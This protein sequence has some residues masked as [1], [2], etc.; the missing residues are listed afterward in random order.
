MRTKVLFTALFLLSVSIVSA[1]RAPA[2]TPQQPAQQD[3]GM[4]LAN[5]IASIAQGVQAMNMQMAVFIEKINSGGMTDKRQKM[6]AGLQALTAAEQRVIF[7]QNNQFDLTLKL[8]DAKAKLAQTEVDLRPMR[9]DRSVQ[10]EGT[11]ETE[12]LRESRRQKLRNDQITLT[13]LV[14]DLGDSL[15]QNTIDLKEAQAFARNLR[16]TYIPQME[17]EMNEQ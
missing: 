5:S 16:K 7:F 10:F 9:I 11:T 2:Q 12:E 14:R 1:Q 13:K 15:E 17:R 8:N 6:V 3:A 4:M